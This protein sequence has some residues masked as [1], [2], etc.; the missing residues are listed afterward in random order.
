MTWIAM[1]IP[2]VFAIVLLAAAGTATAE[3]ERVRYG[4]AKAP[5]KK[6]AA[7]EAGWTQLATPTPASHGTEF[8]VVGKELGP[9]GKLRI[10]AD[11]ATVIVRRVKIYF[12]DGKTKVVQVDKAIAPKKSTEI[13]LKT[14]GPIDHIVVTTESGRGEY[15]LYGSSPAGVASR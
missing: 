8:M 11:K 6:P 14:P 7:D 5:D 1:R 4:D 3:P 10:D 12:D 13:D 15:A 2:S 9:F